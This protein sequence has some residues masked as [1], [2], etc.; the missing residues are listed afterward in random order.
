MKVYECISRLFKVYEGLWK[1]MEVYKG[2]PKLPCAQSR[3]ARTAREHEAPV[4]RNMLSNHTC[5]DGPL[6]TCKASIAVTATIFTVF[7]ANAKET[8][9]EVARPKAAPPLVW[10]RPKAA[11]FVY[12]L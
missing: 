1:Y 6:S 3:M 10:W 7:K 9:K 8:T 11:T 4:A 5:A 12:W 2:K